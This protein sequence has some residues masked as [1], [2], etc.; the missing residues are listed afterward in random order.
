MIAAWYVSSS[1]VQMKTI[2]SSEKQNRRNWRPTVT[3]GTS[4]TPTELWRTCV[5][6]STRSIVLLICFDAM[7]MKMR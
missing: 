6:S 5:A 4:T 3:R 1:E 7:Q 2:D